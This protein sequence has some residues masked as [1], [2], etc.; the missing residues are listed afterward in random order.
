MSCITQN[1]F[2]AGT[3]QAFKMAISMHALRETVNLARG[4]ECYII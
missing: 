3:K 4:A 2:E 1:K